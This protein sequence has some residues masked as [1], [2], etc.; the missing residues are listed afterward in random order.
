MGDELLRPPPHFGDEGSSLSGY[1]CSDC[2]GASLWL[3]QSALELDRVE[4]EDY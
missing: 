2:F 3:A 1:R 4:E